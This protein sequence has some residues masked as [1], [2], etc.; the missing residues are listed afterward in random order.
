M[1]SILNQT[2]VPEITVAEVVYIGGKWICPNT[3]C[4]TINDDELNDSCRECGYDPCLSKHFY[5][6]TLKISLN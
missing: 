3:D 2:Q 4:R 1:D 6:S 5:P